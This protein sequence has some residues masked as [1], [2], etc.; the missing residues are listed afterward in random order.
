M[1][2]AEQVYLK[3]REEINKMPVPFPATSDG[4]ELKLLKHLFS[5]DEAAV[6]ICLNIMPESLKRIY[7]R[8][9]E[10]GITI[11]P[12]ELETMLDRLVDKGAILGGR[13]FESKGMGKKYSLSQLVI[14]MFEFQVDR[15]TPAYSRDF[16]HYIDKGFGDAVLEGNTRQMRVIPLSLSVTPGMKIAPYDDIRAYVRGLKDD[17]AVANCVCRQSAEVLG[18]SSRNSELMETC[19]M[20]K[21]AARFTMGRGHGRAISNNE[22][23]EILDRAENAGFVLEPENCR[24]PNFVCCCCIDC[25]HSLKILKKHPRPAE[26]LVSGYSVSVDPELCKGCKKCVSRCVMDA[27]SMVD[28]VA[29]V[30][31]DRCIGCGVCF[32]ACA[33]DALRL[34][35]NG[36]SHVPPLNHDL[37]YQKIMVERFG[38]WSVLKMVTRIVMGRKA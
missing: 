20:F 27:I 36:K 7:K 17:I 19:L 23:L 21:D 5:S 4:V 31:P 32:T 29:V 26:L 18:G 33:H 14:G 25:C 28:K 10:N 15:I 12:D 37:M 3:L 8:V 24:E 2:A 11:S 16:E 6:A 9:V 22:A 30:N 35:K 13:L 34:N 1:V 38:L